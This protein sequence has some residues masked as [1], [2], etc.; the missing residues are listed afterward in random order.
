MPLKKQNTILAARIKEYEF[1]KN[2]PKTR[3]D[4]FTVCTKEHKEIEK[5]NLLAKI[6]NAA[7]QL[8]VNSLTTIGRPL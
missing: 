8:L 7:T 4:I 3:I 1:I 6:S 5:N 2:C